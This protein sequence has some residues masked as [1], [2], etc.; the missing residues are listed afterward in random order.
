[1]KNIKKISIL[2]LVLLL[3]IP[4]LIFAANNIEIDYKNKED[5]TEISIKGNENRPA[6]ITI[7]NNDRYYLIDRKQTDNNG[8]IKLKVELPDDGTYNCKVVIDGNKTNKQIKVEKKDKDEEDIKDKYNTVDLYIEGYKGVILDK[9][10]IQVGKRE[11]VMDVTLRLLDDN[12][13]KYKVDGWY[14]SSID[15]EKEFDKGKDSGWMFSVNGKFP[16]KGADSIKLKNRDKI[17]WLY[18]YDL[19]KDIGAS[20]KKY[21]YI[22]IERT[23]DDILDKL[24]DTKIKEKDLKALIKDAS[25]YFEDNKPDTSNKS[26]TRYLNRLIDTEDAFRKV[27]NKIDSKHISEEIV[28][29]SISILKEMEKT[30]DKNIEKETKKKVEE[31]LSKYNKLILDLTN[32]LDGK[33]KEKN[34]KELFKITKKINENILKMKLDSK[35]F[36]IDYK[37]DIELS[38]TLINLLIENKVEE[39]KILDKNNNEIIINIEE[40]KDSDIKIETKLSKNEFNINI[41]KDKKEIKS[42]EKDITIILDNK[43]LDIGRE[44]INITKENKPITYKNKENSIIIKTKNTGKYKIENIKVEFKDIKQTPWAKEAIEKMNSRGIIKGRN[45]K[46][47]APKDN[48]TRAE[49]TALIDRL[50]DLETSSNKNPFKDIKDDKWYKKS[51]IAA[52]ENKL[53]NGKKENIFDPDGNITRAETAKILGQILKQEGIQIKGENPLFKDKEKIAKWAEEGIVLCYE[54]KILKGY[55]DQTFLP[56]NKVTR[57]ETAVMLDRLYEKILEK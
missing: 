40:F 32:K 30:I 56:Q 4:N 54:N 48:I 31:I 13:I 21:N 47:F 42:L 38:K 25:K 44:N 2:L 11:T 37:E 14:I 28:D 43:Y 46:E 51:V 7:S 8:N 23:L 33:E 29:A 3:L 20:S 12:K 57:A 22:N 18:T 39:I 19:G 15:G 49:F 24:D 55:K 5:Y 50:L 1:M 9:K 52:Y 27:S 45:N 10:H 36:L 16:E 41:L 6:T 35:E 53:V 17:K 34:I 26:I